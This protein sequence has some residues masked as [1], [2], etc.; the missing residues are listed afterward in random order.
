M[1]AKGKQKSAW[2]RHFFYRKESWRTTWKLRL[3]LLVLVLVA[4]VGGRQ[5]WE[6]QIGESL[7]CDQQTPHS[8]A[9]L[10]ENF[11][12]DYHIFERAEFLKRT[13]IAPRVFVPASA[14]DSGEFSS[15]ERGTVELFT[16]IAGLKEYEQIPIR[17]IEPISLNAANQ[18]RE[19]LAKEHI[20]S[21]IVISPGFRSRRS[22]LVYGTVLNPIGIRVSC[23]P[24]FGGVTPANWTDSWHGIQD[25][26]EHFIKL[27]YY[28][29]WV[30]L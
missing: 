7:V 23:D 16:R 5:F 11:D 27:Q 25:V 22:A 21:V 10:L 30:L 19:V 9:L 28:R 12:T 20:Q 24:V 8:D 18:I 15:V 1:A 14:Y 3:I 26:L 29:F 4:V 17:L 6:R 13:G 2:Y